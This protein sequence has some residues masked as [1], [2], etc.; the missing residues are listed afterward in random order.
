MLRLLSWRIT[1]L[2]DLDSPYVWQGIRSL[3]LSKLLTC[4]DCTDLVLLL[5]NKHLELH[6]EHLLVALLLHRG[7]LKIVRIQTQ[8]GE[9][10]LP[11]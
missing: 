6:V 8:L 3:S 2:L 1:P 7:L 9:V 10:C 5:L 11:S 4:C